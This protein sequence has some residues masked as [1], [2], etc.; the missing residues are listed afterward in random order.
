MNKFHAPSPHI[1]AVLPFFS[2]KYR[3]DKQIIKECAPAFVKYL[4]YLTTRNDENGLLAIGLGDWCP[5]TG[6]GEKR[7]PVIQSSTFMFYEICKLMEGICLEFDIGDAP[8]YSSLA[9]KI[10]EAIIENFYD[11]E[12]HT[13]KDVLDDDLAAAIHTLLGRKRFKGYKVES[14]DIQIVGRPNRKKYA[15]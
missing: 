4:H 2:Y 5:P 7:I 12:N 9:D 8:Y 1:L 10:K 14:I 3:G 6:N 15:I 13:F 11:K